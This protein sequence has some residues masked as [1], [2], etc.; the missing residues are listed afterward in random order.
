MGNSSETSCR[1]CRPIGIICFWGPRP[2]R[3]WKRPVLFVISI[4]ILL[5]GAVVFFLP[6]Q[7]TP[8][9]LLPLYV[10]SGFVQFIGLLGLIVSLLG[11]NACVARTFGDA[12]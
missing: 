5:L 9:E 6:P 11:C 10:L 3:K 2:A 4:P 12:F 1:L 8:L 7:Y